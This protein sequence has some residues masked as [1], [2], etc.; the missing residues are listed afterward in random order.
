M[1]NDG[2]H[3]PL[4]KAGYFLGGLA[5]ALKLPL[6]KGQHGKLWMETRTSNQKSINGGVEDH[7]T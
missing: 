2:L 4:K 1:A 7:P 3:N 5:F 6:L